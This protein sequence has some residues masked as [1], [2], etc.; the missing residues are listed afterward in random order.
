MAAKD[1]ARALFTCMYWPGDSLAPRRAF[2]SKTNPDCQRKEDFR[3]AIRKSRSKM[4]FCITEEN[5]VFYV[6]RRDQAIMENRYRLPAVVKP[7]RYT[8]E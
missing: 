7:V 6:H 3:A 8:Y 5:P 1:I 4:K 2:Q